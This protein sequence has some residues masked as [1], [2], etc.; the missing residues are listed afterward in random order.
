MKILIRNVLALI[1]G[2]LLGSVVNMTIIMLGPILIPPPP[3]VDGTNLESLVATM[4][5]F[6]PKH[7]VAPFVAHSMGTLV[8]ALTAFLI[9]L[10]YG[11]LFAYLIGF[12][13]LIG[14]FSMVIMIP[15]PLWFSLLDLIVA[16]L[17]MA[18]LGIFIGRRIS[19]SK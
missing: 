11:R 14:G 17:P 2:F 3:G 16:Y 4:H 8:G 5:L 13:F 12:T 9:A 18:W 1:L 6:E 15:S 10:S 19:A 7:F